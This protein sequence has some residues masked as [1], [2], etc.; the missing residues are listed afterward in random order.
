MFGKTEIFRRTI[1]LGLCFP[2]AYAF[3][4]ENEDAVL[5]HAKVHDIR[6]GHVYDHAWAELKGKVYD[7]Q[8][9]EV[10]KKS[11]QDIEGFYELHKPFDIK[12]YNR[13]EAAIVLVRTGKHGPWTDREEEM[14]RKAVRHFEEKLAKRKRRRTP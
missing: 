12:K 14:G 6:D 1:P 7:W 13:V 11:P 10:F 8:T 4:R 9:I 2:Y 3:V 5:V